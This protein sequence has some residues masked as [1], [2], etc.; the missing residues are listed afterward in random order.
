[1]TQTLIMFD[2]D[3]TL[4]SIHVFKSLAGWYKNGPIQA[5]Y[6][7]S[8][9]GQTIR[10]I[11]LDKH[12]EDGFAQFALG[13]HRRIRALRKLFERLRAEHCELLVCSKGLVGPIRKILHDADL[14]Q[15]MAAIYANVKTDYGSNDFD[16][17]CLQRDIPHN[18][19]SFL[20]STEGNQGG[21]YARYGGKEKLMALLL[22]ER[23]LSQ[24][25]GILV[26]DD[27]VEI[28][29]ARKICRTQFIGGENGMTN[30]H[31]DELVHMVSSQKER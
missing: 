25:N 4:S 2:F 23:G 19:D 1:M 26:E 18:V 9:I 15:F 11:E 29:K 6:A 13:G 21:S 3:L 5:P 10:S 12:F 17:S 31:M 8:E 24:K 14:L 28:E 16:D 27:E 20:A 7:L 22:R 30:E